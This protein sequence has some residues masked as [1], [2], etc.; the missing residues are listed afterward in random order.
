LTAA[1]IIK[2]LKK[3]VHIH[4]TMELEMWAKLQTI[5]YEINNN[6]P[7]RMD[8]FLEVLISWFIYT[9]YDNIENMTK[10]DPFYIPKEMFLKR[11]ME[12]REILNKFN[13]EFSKYF[14][15]IMRK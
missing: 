1:N 7:M 12:K 3:G 14:K 10:G 4:T 2:D 6:K 15:N 8:I 13:K 11:K 5:L 9:Y